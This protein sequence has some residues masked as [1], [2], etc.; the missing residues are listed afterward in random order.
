MHLNIDGLT[1]TNLLS[2][3]DNVGRIGSTITFYSIMHFLMFLFLFIHIKTLFNLISTKY[4]EGKKF[5]G[6]T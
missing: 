1:L 4:F 5:C 6:E 2:I 3:E